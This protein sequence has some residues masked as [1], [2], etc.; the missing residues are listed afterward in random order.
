MV[1]CTT[2]ALILPAVTVENK[3]LNSNAAYVKSLTITGCV[4]GTTPF[5]AN[6]DSGNDSAEN[7][8][9]VRTFDSV[10]YSF[11]VVMESI[12]SSDS[13][14]EARVKLEFVLPLT[15]EQAEFDQ[16]KMGW[17]DQTEDYTP[18][19]KTETRKIDEVNTECRVLTCYKHLIKTDGTVVPGEFENNLTV[20]VKS[21]KNGDEFAPIINATMEYNYETKSV[22][23][24]VVKVSATPRYNIQI[25]G[26]TAYKDTFDF[27]TGNATAQSYG[28]GY[29][30]GN[31]T[32]RVVKLGLV[33]QLYNDN[34]AKGFKGIELP[35]GDITFDLELDV[36]YTY[37]DSGGV[38][39]T[40]DVNSKDKYMPRLWS[41]DA[42]VWTNYGASNADGRV[43]K[44]SS[45]CEA[46]LAPYNKNTDGDYNS[47][48][49]G[50]SWTATQSGNTIS[51]TVKNY[52]IDI[53]K[54]PTR[55]GDRANKDYYG[56]NLGIGCFSAGEIWVVQPFN[57]IGDTGAVTENDLDI[58]KDYGSDNGGVFNNTFTVKNMNATSIGG[59]SSTE[60]QKTDDD[61]YNP[62]LQ[63]FAPGVLQN[64]VCYTNAAKFDGEG[65]GVKVT[66]NGQDCATPGTSL[67]FFGGLS[68]KAN[69]EADNRLYWATNLTKFYGSAF[70]PNGLEP[71]KTF[72]KMSAG[73]D[74]SQIDMKVLYATKLDG[75][76]WNS[77][78]ELQRTYEDDLIFYN[79]PEDIPDGHLCVGILY[80]F[81]GPGGEND[82]EAYYTD[83]VGMT[84]RNDQ[85]LV[86]KTYMLASTSRLWT[87][88]MFENDERYSEAVT[89][90]TV[91]DTIPDWTNPETNL[92]SFPA[93]YY[94]SGNIDGSVFY[95][96]AEYAD[97]KFTEHNSEWC[98]WGDTMLVIGYKTGINKTLM[99][100]DSGDTKD[101]FLIDSNQT[102]VD[103]KLQPSTRF[104]KKSPNNIYTTTVT[105]EDTLPGYLYYRAGSSYFGGEYTQTS[106]SGGTQGTIEGGELREPKV[107]NNSDGTQT[108]TWVIENVT[109]GNPLPAIYYSANIGDQSDP[110]KVFPV[111]TLE[112]LNKVRISATDDLRAPSATNGDYPQIKPADTYDVSVATEIWDGGTDV[113]SVTYDGGTG[114]AEDPYK[115]STGAQLYKMV[116]ENCGGSNA[117]TNEYYELTNDIFLNDVSSEKWYEADGLHQWISFTNNADRGF[118]DILLGNGYTVYGL[119]GTDITG[120][121]GLIPMLG[122]GQVIGV[123]IRNAYL[124]GKYT[125]YNSLGG[126]TG[127]I[128]N[129][130][131]DGK[132]NSN[133]KAV[134]DKCSVRDITFAGEAKS[135]GGIAGALPCLTEITNCCFVGNLDSVT[136]DEKGAIY[137][138][139][140]GST[141]TR[142]KNSYSVGTISSST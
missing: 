99:Q 108:L 58:L 60:Q 37:T 75:K 83:C 106:D 93:G 19:L 84:L 46:N 41:C 12:N 43:L 91:L 127:Y 132:G 61:T 123:N 120:V 126:I 141:S 39:Q 97:G 98:H 88:S 28:D 133:G 116:V 142:I 47:C 24:D 78:E 51:I 110:N 26:H 16:S 67:Y 66:T 102:V 81:T 80:C 68:Y 7:N 114:T 129:G 21:M 59:I 138:A 18:T 113:T 76:D 107:T 53:D 38:K 100:K 85:S 64:R 50:G 73:V 49:N 35:S 23:A 92:S 89:N 86:G 52:E 118:N 34:P 57:K 140:W 22:T 5:D 27:S 104:E 95:R 109:V 9:I 124:S 63:I 122:T 62:E 112:L 115:I 119:Y 54:M 69:N 121:C 72:Y 14:T 82:D 3:P 77:D 137:G 136:A 71:T 101:R 48:Y 17:M 105:I 45:G 65:V 125:N 131:V 94:N 103:F 32:G 96:K 11:K 79:S 134:I 10:N 36:N 117:T 29:N 31:V 70:E 56:F 40:V 8:K 30:I 111:G 130:S 1:F 87:E 128:K 55:N 74:A 42:N 25:G 20:K 15:S 13:F 2:Y 135:V 44:D 33:L 90:G 139:A 6:D 4:D